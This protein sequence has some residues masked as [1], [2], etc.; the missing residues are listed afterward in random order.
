[1]KKLAI[2]IPFKLELD[3]IGLDLNKFTKLSEFKGLDLWSNSDKSL[4]IAICGQ[5]K[6]STAI[7][8]TKLHVSLDI[9]EFWLVGSAGGHK[10]DFNPIKSGQLLLANQCFE[11]DFV[12]MISSNKQ[13]PIP[14]YKY[15]SS[16]IE[17]IEI[18]LNKYSIDYN[19]AKIL[20][21]DKDI[22]DDKLKFSLLEKYSPN[23]FACFCWE[24][25]GF[26]RAARQNKVNYLELRVV[27]DSD[28]LDFADFKK[29]LFEFMPLVLK[30][31]EDR[32]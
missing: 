19:L 29:K 32:L 17:N 14:K 6:V 8:L 16:S 4:F 3:A 20:S 25:A 13:R 10:C 22:F 24:S 11:Y 5:G 28:F 27:V 30:L 18:M 21:A 31:I 26:C 2:L 23:D 9:D 1:M 7:T 12:S 15:S